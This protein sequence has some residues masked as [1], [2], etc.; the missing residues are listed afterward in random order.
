[1]IY[2]VRQNRKL[3]LTSLIQ[4]EKEIVTELLILR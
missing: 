3:Y 4:M 2:A 1:M